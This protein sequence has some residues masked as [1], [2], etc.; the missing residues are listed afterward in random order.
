MKMEISNKWFMN[1]ENQRL[2]PSMKLKKNLIL[3][4]YG[5]ALILN[6]FL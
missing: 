2:S 4:L 5:L 3:A 1:Y 6:F